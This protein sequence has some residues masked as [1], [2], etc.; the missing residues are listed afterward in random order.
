ME[1]VEFPSTN[2]FKLLDLCVKLKLI[3][4]NREK[5]KPTFLTKV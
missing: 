3:Y 4:Q 1:T 5:L 2:I